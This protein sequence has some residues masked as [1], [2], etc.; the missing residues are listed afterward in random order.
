MLTDQSRK[1]NDYDGN[2]GKC[3]SPGDSPLFSEAK[4]LLSV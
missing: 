2:N 3:V 4:T 1:E